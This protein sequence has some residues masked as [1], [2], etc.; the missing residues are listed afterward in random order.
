MEVYH[1]IERYTFPGINVRDIIHTRRTKAVKIV[2]EAKP[3]T[4]PSL[5]SAISSTSPFASID[6]SSSA[7][8][9]ANM[10]NPIIDQREILTVYL[11]N[12]KPVMLFLASKK[13]VTRR[14]IRD[15]NAN[16]QGVVVSSESSSIITS[17]SKE[18]VPLLY[19]MLNASPDN[20]DQI[21]WTGNVT[22]LFPYSG[23]G[24]DL[25]SSIFELQRWSFS[26][27]AG[28][29]LKSYTETSYTVKDV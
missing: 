19:T 4:N 9:I 27:I 17:D 16:L 22:T 5:N 11:K 15:P 6:K 26:G 2:V 13:I 28:R 18:P 25:Y 21:A 12:T 14:I 24:T 10:R 23:L 29:Y 20:R 8:F 7:V 1:L 3:S